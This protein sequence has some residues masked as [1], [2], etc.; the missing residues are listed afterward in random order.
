MKDYCDDIKEIP[1]HLCGKCY[2]GKNICFLCEDKIREYLENPFYIWDELPV[3][4]N[5]SGWIFLL[6]EKIKQKIRRKKEKILSLRLKLL[7]A[8][9]M[10]QKRLQKEIEKYQREIDFYNPQGAQKW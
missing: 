2:R 10:K 3:D 8:E 9:G 1:T 5:F 7:C 6:R 4:C